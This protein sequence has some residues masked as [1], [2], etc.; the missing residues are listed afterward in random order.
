MSKKSFL[1]HEYGIDKNFAPVTMAGDPQMR[2]AAFT[3]AQH[4][5]QKVKRLAEA[6]A[7]DPATIPEKVVGYST[8]AEKF[9][10]PTGTLGIVL[11]GGIALET[12]IK[13]ALEIE[14]SFHNRNG[15]ALAGMTAS[16]ADDPELAS[17]IADQSTVVG[18][19]AVQK[20]LDAQ[21]GDNQSSDAQEEG[22]GVNLGRLAASVSQANA[23]LNKFNV[24]LQRFM[25]K[26]STINDFVEWVFGHTID[27][28]AEKIQ[29]LMS[30]A[31][32]TI[33]GSIKVT[34]LGFSLF[35]L[36]ASAESRSGDQA[37][38]KANS[39]IILTRGS[40]YGG[41][42]SVW[43]YLAE[44]D[45]GNVTSMIVSFS[46]C[47]A[48]ADM[49]S[50][51]GT[52]TTTPEDEQ[53]MDERIQKRWEE[54]QA[55]LQAF[56]N[57]PVFSFLNKL[58]EISA[59]AAGV[60]SFLKLFFENVFLLVGYLLV[61]MLLG[62]WLS[63]TWNV[64]VE[65]LRGLDTGDDPDMDAL[66]SDIEALQELQNYWEENH[67]NMSDFY[68][69]ALSVIRARMIEIMNHKTGDPFSGEMCDALTYAG[70]Y[71]LVFSFNEVVL[72][73]LTDMIM[74]IFYVKVES[75]TLNNAVDLANAI[76]T[77]SVE[78]AETLA[79]LA[80]NTVLVFH[81]LQTLNDELQ[82]LTEDNKVSKSRVLAR[83][84]NR[85]CGHLPGL[86]YV[87]DVGQGYYT[88]REA[89]ENTSQA[90]QDLEQRLGLMERRDKLNS[91][92]ALAQEGAGSSTHPAAPVVTRSP[93]VTRSESRRELDVK[94]ALKKFVTSDAETFIKKPGKWA[95]DVKDRNQGRDLR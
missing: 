62:L 9:K 45:I 73:M 93:R 94:Q 24:D 60:F 10:R 5:E 50:A 95:R 70:V 66:L 31:G 68:L 12:A 13:P 39:D 59:G 80:Q 61:E 52:E 79:L 28:L 36:L 75:E 23:V 77:F 14:E 29:Q 48:I 17:Q 38:A 49:L 91:A 47:C 81:H 20:V 87:F 85:T 67:L 6:E 42:R 92:R 86:R 40:L 83:I 63:A 55:Q 25:D 33:F 26:V 46:F 19:E 69:T 78:F 64:L 74:D 76:N 22:S 84:Y 51:W 82:M 56:L 11:T 65:V 3:I 15:I 89:L 90:K 72:K 44:S 8:T 88:G 58:G 4:F 34:D 43:D 35:D 2:A 27:P 57:N 53:A 54:L 1:S 32:Q 16:V 18:Q 71:W 41:A 7:N 37:R 21:Q 30:Y